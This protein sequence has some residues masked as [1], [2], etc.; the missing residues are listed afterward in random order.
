MIIRKATFED[1]FA[2]SEHLFLAMED[3]LYAFIG[4]KNS[5]KAKE[6]LLSFVEKEDNQY[7]YQNCL[8]AEHM[9]EIT[10]AV[11]IYDGAKADRL[12]E[13][14]VQYIRT[15]FDINF[16]PEK[17]TQQ[18]EYYIDSFGVS[19]HLQGKGVGTQI[20]KFIIKEYVDNNQLTLGLLVDEENPLAEKLYLRLGFEFAGQKV[21][22][23]KK[24]KHL[25]RKPGYGP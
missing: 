9:K 16:N 18:G 10:G 8:V 14:I 22:A 24:M 11:N 13:P 21:L 12:T 1:S 6:L 2:I 20:L 5:K 4:E 23:G 15:H 19:P 3:I 7:S 17:E 25:Q